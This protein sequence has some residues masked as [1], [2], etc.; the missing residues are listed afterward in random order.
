MDERK[1]ATLG[2]GPHSR[3]AE[4]YRSDTTPRIQKVAAVLALHFRRARRVVG[5]D[6]VESSIAQAGPQLFA[7]FAL[8]DRR[9][10]F[11]Q[12]LPVA[13]VPGGESQIVRAR[14]DA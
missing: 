2:F 6:H 12:G 1:A 7:V 13:D 4:L 8:A 14:F 3:K 10:T 5:G 11:E 9:R